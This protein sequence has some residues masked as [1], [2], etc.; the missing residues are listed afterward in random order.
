MSD[1]EN[2]CPLCGKQLKRET[3]E[4]S[5]QGKNLRFVYDQSADWCDECNES[6]L[7]PDDFRPTRDAR[8]DI[9][10]FNRL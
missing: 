7:C 1:K 5:V 4:I 3:R 10:R 8:S 9:Y 6:F 2:P